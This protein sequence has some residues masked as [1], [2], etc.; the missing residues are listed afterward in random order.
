MSSSVQP[1]TSDVYYQAKYWNHYK[2]PLEYIS[3]HFTGDP[4]KPWWDYFKEMYAKKPFQHALILNCGDGR[5]E[6][7]LYDLGIF[8][9]ATAF[10]ISSELLKI[11]ERK[12]ERRKITYF[13]ADA[14]TVDFKENTF[15]LVVNVAS[16]HH[17][18]YL[19]RMMHILA[20]AIK[21]EGMIVNFD[22]VG[23]HRNQ[24]SLKQW[25][26]INIFN[27]KL[28]QHLR[29]KK[30]YYPEIPTMIKE[31]PSEAIHPDLLFPTLDRYFDIVERNDVGGG[32]AYMIITHN[33]ALRD[34][35]ETE[36][37]TQ[38]KQILKWDEEYYQS[39]LTPP[40]FSF[41]VAQPKKKILKNKK[42]IALWQ[43]EENQREDWASNH[44]GTYS[45]FHFIQTFLY[46][47]KATRYLYKGLWL[48]VYKVIEITTLITI[49]SGK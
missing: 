22:Y 45:W 17:I 19:N 38:L 39:G 3:R 9:K 16:L 14:N 44:L 2:I 20:K 42:Q 49:K 11:C 25:A 29:N 28:P 23:P 4:H 34:A 7:Q 40:M 36:I 31:D 32:I 13:R 21:P 27:N 37:E 41:F 35:E 43:Q 24:Y 46:R 5:H 6:R 33:D 30:L 26:L 15:D 48:L 1:T 12:K 18:Q 47:W 10:D 8:K